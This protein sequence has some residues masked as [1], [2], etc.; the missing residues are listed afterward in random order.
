MNNIEG[1]TLK[2][3]IVCMTG[4]AKGHE[5]EINDK[6]IKDL[7]DSTGILNDCEECM[8][9][10]LKQINYKTQYSFIADNFLRKYGQDL[11]GF[12]KNYFSESELFPVWQ[13]LN[14]IPTYKKK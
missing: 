12:L 3:V 10:L 1:N 14:N 13:H 4:I 8:Q 6:F 9:G 7:K 2:D 11:T 5:F